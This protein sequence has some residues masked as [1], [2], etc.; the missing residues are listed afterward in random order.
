MAREATNMTFFVAMRVLTGDRSALF[1]QVDLAG[2]IA[3]IMSVQHS[4][5]GS[6]AFLI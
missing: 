4:V 6:L 2:K 3:A 1:P 5:S